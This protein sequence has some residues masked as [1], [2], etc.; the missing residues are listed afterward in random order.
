M[1]KWA[2]FS[3]DWVYVYHLAPS[4]G[5]NKKIVQNIVICSSENQF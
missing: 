1:Y 5:E 4:N 3:Q 2:D